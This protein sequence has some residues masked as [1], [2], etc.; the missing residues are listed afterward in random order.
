MNNRRKGLIC[1]FAG[2]IIGIPCFLLLPFPYGNIA[3][4][5]VIGIGWVLQIKIGGRPELC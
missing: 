2:V 4:L 5:I 3:Q 1:G